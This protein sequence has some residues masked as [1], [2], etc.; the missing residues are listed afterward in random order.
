MKST[1]KHRLQSLALL[2]AMGLTVFLLVAQRKAAKE[3]SPARYGCRLWVS[4]GNSA[5]QPV[6]PNSGVGPGDVEEDFPANEDAHSRRWKELDDEIPQFPGVRPTEAPTVMGASR[7]EVFK[8]GNQSVIGRPGDY[9]LEFHG[10]GFIAS[11]GTPLVHIGDSIMLTDTHVG[12]EGN[13]LSAVMPADV[14]AELER[15]DI[16]EFAIQ[17]PGGLDRERENWGRLVVIKALLLKQIREAQTRDF[18]QGTFF[19]ERK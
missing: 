15:R 18:V 5:L 13:L 1:H 6:D 14:A 16:R 3:D 8:I 4:E 2:L 10:H 19:L 7:V 12:A 9:V 11:E 17:N